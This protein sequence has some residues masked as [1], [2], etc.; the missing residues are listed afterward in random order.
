M[1]IRCGLCLKAEAVIELPCQALDA[2]LRHFKLCPISFFQIRSIS[3]G[4]DGDYEKQ[5]KI[6]K[7]S[8]SKSDSYVQNDVHRRGGREN[9]ESRRIFPHAWT[10]NNWNNCNNIRIVLYECRLDDCVDRRLQYSRQW[11]GKFEYATC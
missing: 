4:V 11:S 7:L 6:S 1:A 8:Q 9:I 3:A 10:L 5:R 2:Y